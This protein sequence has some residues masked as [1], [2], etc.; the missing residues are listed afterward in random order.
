MRPR[1]VPYFI[2]N[3]SGRTYDY[4]EVGLYAAARFEEAHS[5]RKVHRRT[6]GLA[7]ALS[8]KWNI[9]NLSVF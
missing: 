3:A 7:N 8:I 4:E 9:G 5:C 1:N 2:D 6:F